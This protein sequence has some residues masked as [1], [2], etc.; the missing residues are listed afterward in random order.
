MDLGHPSS[1]SRLSRSVRQDRPTETACHL[2][3]AVA[4]AASARA[5]RCCLTPAT[6][7][8][9]PAGGV[10]RCFRPP[11]ADRGRTASVPPEAGTSPHCLAGKVS[12]ET[13]SPGLPPRSLLA[14]H[15]H[16]QAVQARWSSRRRTGNHPGRLRASC[17][18]YRL[19]CL[20]LVASRC[21]PAVD[22]GTNLR[23]KAAV[24][25]PASLDAR[26]DFWEANVEALPYPSP[27]DVRSSASTLRQ[28]T[29]KRS[30]A[31]PG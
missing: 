10:R 16:S 26:L 18:S 11:F 15:S 14:P 30:P 3:R 8:V 25:E 7:R 17:V 4:S 28:L 13:Y 24:S 29:P 19:R 6:G 27:I 5:S 2:S 1:V 21:D 20:S 12:R 22:G 9:R 23:Q 31:C